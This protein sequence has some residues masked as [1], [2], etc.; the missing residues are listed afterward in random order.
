MIPTRKMFI[1][2]GDAQEGE[3]VKNLSNMQDESMIGLGIGKRKRAEN[4]NKRQ[5]RS[6]M[7]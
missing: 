1:D 6:R 2:N 7:V 3:G 5:T 4:A